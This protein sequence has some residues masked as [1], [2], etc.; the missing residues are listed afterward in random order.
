MHETLLVEAWLHR[1]GELCFPKLFEFGY[2]Y[3]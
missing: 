2:G 3:A 1:A